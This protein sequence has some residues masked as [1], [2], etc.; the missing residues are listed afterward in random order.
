MLNEKN[1]DRLERFKNIKKPIIPARAK[2]PSLKDVEN[3]RKANQKSIKLMKERKRHLYN[4]NWLTEG[5]KSPNYK[6]MD[7]QI[8]RHQEKNLRTGPD[9]SLFD[10]KYRNDS[11]NRAMKM[12]SIKDSLLRGE[13]P[14]QDTRGGAYK[15]RGNPDADHRAA[16]TKNPMNKPARRVKNPGVGEKGDQV[17]GRKRGMNR[18]YGTTRLIKSKDGQGYSGSTKP[19]G[20]RKDVK[21]NTNEEYKP[22]PMS[23]MLKKTN[24][25][26]SDMRTEL[27]KARNS[28]DIANKTENVRAFK[29]HQYNKDERTN[30]IEGILGKRRK[31][32]QQVDMRNSD[33]SG[34]SSSRQSR[35]V[36]N[37]A[38]YL[39][40]ST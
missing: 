14:R 6:K 10:P 16:Y 7:K 34:Y 11:R 18:V 31:I 2:A 1:E 36:S 35:S 27:K 39:K 9:T 4:E 23:K 21:E 40:K 3:K 15:K 38:K 32:R 28:R 29:R 12:D 22:L 13:D 19:L 17:G 33:P 5:Y 8:S 37:K 30:K 24:K 20:K 26:T 25:Y